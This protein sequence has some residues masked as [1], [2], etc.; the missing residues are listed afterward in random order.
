MGSPRS[1]KKRPQ[2]NH[3]HWRVKEILAATT[4]LLK[5]RRH[6]NSSY[7]QQLNSADDR[8]HDSDI[9][10]TNSMAGFLHFSASEKTHDHSNYE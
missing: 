9:R 4:R 6:T 5:M 3:A 8:G 1:G 2:T 7:D 10:L